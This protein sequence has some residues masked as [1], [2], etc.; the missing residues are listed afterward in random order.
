SSS[1][2]PLRARSTTQLATLSLHDALPIYPTL[3]NSWRASLLRQLYDAT[4]R[5]L[6]RG[7]ANPLDREEQICQTQSAAL[8]L[9]AAAGIDPDA[10]EQL[11][12]QL[13]DD[14]FLRHSADDIAWHTRAI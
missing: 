9:L 6:N 2:S 8:D 14:Y 1:S 4:L 13:G 12:S 5:A 7:L 10:A 3:W 11:W